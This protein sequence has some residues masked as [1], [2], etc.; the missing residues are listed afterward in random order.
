[1][2]LDTLPAVQNLSAQ[3]KWRLAV[4]LWDELI[5]DV[6]DRRDNAIQELIDRRM[7]SYRQN[8]ESATTWDALK[9]RMM[10]PRHA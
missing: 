5:P 10:M 9:Q 6:E 2:I 3:D 4:E 8:P 7:E 1:M